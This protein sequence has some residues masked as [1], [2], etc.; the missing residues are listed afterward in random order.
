ML[1]KVLATILIGSLEITSIVFFA[2][3]LPADLPETIGEAAVFTIGYIS[4]V[5]VITL[6]LIL[7]LRLIW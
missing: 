6:P 2:L 7:V 5:I 3:G 4:F 1:A